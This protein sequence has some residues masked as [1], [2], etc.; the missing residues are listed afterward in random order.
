M[1]KRRRYR[2]Y[3]PEFKVRVVLELLQGH[4]SAA[5]LSREHGI[6]PARLSEWQQQFMERAPLIFAAEPP[7]AEEQKRIAELERLVGQLTIEL[8]ASKKVSSLLDSR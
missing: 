2:R 8:A 3:S 1:G 5:Q 4:K 6:A 7:H